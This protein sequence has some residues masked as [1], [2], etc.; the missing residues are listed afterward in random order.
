MCSVLFTFPGKIAVSQSEGVANAGGSTREVSLQ[1]SKGAK[2]A[3][4]GAERSSAVPHSLNKD[5]TGQ[6]LGPAKTM[7]ARIRHIWGSWV[8]G[9]WSPTGSQASL[10][11]AFGKDQEMRLLPQLFAWPWW[12]CSGCVMSVLSIGTERQSPGI[13]KGLPSPVVCS[14]L[15]SQEGCVVSHYV[16][17]QHSSL[18]ASWSDPLT[19]PVFKAF[20]TFDLWFK[21]KSVLWI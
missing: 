8:R 12:M 15:D 17:R 16:W 9:L 4:A 19:M 5:T 21:G 2:S 6:W 11:G 1:P 7:T 20:F 13:G 18:R 3:G 14:R 10:Q